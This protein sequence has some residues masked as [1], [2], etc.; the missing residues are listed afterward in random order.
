MGR[1]IAGIVV[2]F[3]LWTA[4]WLGFTSGMQAAFPGVIQAEQ[5]LTH[6]GALL[7]YI[8]YSVLISALAGFACAAVRKE[9]PMRTVWVFALIQLLV[10]IGFEASYWSMTPVWYHLVFLVLIV[11]ATVWGGSLKERGTKFATA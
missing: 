3:L 9:S 4:L 6:T 10:G 5:P 11:P 1:S 8:V 2:G 7:A